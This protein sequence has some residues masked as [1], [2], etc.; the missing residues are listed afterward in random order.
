MWPQI[1]AASL[2]LAGSTICRTS[3]CS[4]S[5]V[6]KIHPRRF[7]SKPTHLFPLCLDPFLHYLSIELTAAGWDTKNKEME[8]IHIGGCW[9]KALH[10]AKAILDIQKTSSALHLG[11]PL[12]SGHF[13]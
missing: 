5:T 8:K 10:N 6:H 9:T 12:L 3:L 7:P 2:S 13:P 1:G 4:P 11:Q